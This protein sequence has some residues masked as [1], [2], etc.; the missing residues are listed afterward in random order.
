MV[1]SPPTHN[2]LGFLNQTFFPLLSRNL[3]RGFVLALANGLPF[4]WFIHLRSSLP[5]STTGMDLDKK[6]F[7]EEGR[8]PTSQSPL[9]YETH[10]T[11]TGFVGGMDEQTVDE[12][13][14]KVRIDKYVNKI[15]ERQVEGTMSRA[16][17]TATRPDL[18]Q[19]VDRGTFKLAFSR[20]QG[21]SSDTVPVWKPPI[22][23]LLKNLLFE[24]PPAG[25]PSH[26]TGNALFVRFA[27]YNWWASDFFLLFSSSFLSS[28][29]KPFVHKAHP[30][31]GPLV[32]VPSLSF[33]QFLPIWHAAVLGFGS[34][35]DTACARVYTRL[36]MA[37]MRL[38]LA[39]VHKQLA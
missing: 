24:K 6:H 22:K 19:A 39:Y 12:R 17:F 27:A 28:T 18:H 4:T 30:P 15:I 1:F 5:R 38:R 9:Q 33:G 29:M 31:S 34:L 2:Q 3:N 36:H 7:S 35:L 20:V 8:R 21:C 32:W 37:H 10:T 13:L 16:R 25:Q 14:P 11:L 23:G 26:H